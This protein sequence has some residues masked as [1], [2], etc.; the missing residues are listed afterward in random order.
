[1]HEYRFDNANHMI[2]IC[3][4]IFYFIAGWSPEP[5]EAAATRNRGDLI[6]AGN[7]MPRAT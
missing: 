1:M 5:T 6:A 4:T 2:R 3:G 7:D